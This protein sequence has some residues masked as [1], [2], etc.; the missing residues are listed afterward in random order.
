LRRVIS[1][2][3]L[4]EGFHRQ[5]RKVTKTQAQFPTDAALVQM[6]YLAGQ[7]AQRKWTRRVPNWGEILG[8]LV[9]YFEDRLTPY[10]H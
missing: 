10:L 7:E 4:L 2:T 8:Q 5:R 1:T 3:N 9:I 6:L